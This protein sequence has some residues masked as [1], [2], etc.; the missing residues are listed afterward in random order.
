MNLSV[1]DKQCFL[2]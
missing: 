2:N 1:D